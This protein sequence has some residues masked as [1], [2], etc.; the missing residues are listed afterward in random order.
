[1]SDV[2]ELDR[3]L[4]EAENVKR[5]LQWA[6]QDRLFRRT[7]GLFI[8]GVLAIVPLVIVFGEIGA[9]IAASW[10]VISSLPILGLGLHTILRGCFT[11]PPRR[12]PTKRYNYK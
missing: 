6:R 2:P 9:V 11:D 1:M 12:D 3:L 7:L 10:I 8:I 4:D 5:N